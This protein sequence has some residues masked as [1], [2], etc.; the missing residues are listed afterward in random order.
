MD[1]LTNLIWSMVVIGLFSIFMGVLGVDASADV[2][3]ISLAIIVAGCMA[4]G[5]D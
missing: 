3:S 5:S 2:V 4:Y 1:R